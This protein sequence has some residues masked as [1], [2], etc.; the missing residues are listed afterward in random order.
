MK[1]FDTVRVNKP[2]LNKFD[3]SH[4]RKMSLD[5]GNLYPI[6]CEE[7]L[8]GEKWR[9][10]SDVFLRFLALIA[11]VM[12]RVD[13]TVHY[14]FVPN[15]LV[16]K[17]WQTFIS[18][19]EDGLQAPV[20]PKFQMNTVYGVSPAYLRNGSLLDYLGFPT[21]ASGNAL[22]AF[23]NTNQFNLMPLRVYQLIYD[24]FY[25]DQNVEASQISPT[26]FL[27]D[28]LI[29]V[30]DVAATFTLRRRAWEKDYLTSCLPWTQRGAPVSIPI[31]SAITVRGG[32][33]LGSGGYPRMNLAGTGA[34]V[35]VGPVSLDGNPS[36]IST[37]VAGSHLIY[38]PQDT[39]QVSSSSL[40]V[41]ALRQSI[42][43]QQWLENNAR[44]GS[45]YIEQLRAHFGVVSSDARLQRPQYLG[46]GKQPVVIS[47]VL[48]SAPASGGSTGLATMAGHGMSVG[49]TNQFQQYFEEH[50]YVMGLLSVTPRTAYQQGY[51]KT[52]TRL[53]NTD[54]Y[55]PEFAGLGEQSVFGGESYYDCSDGS[56][57][58]QAAFVA[59]FGYQSRYA[60]YK[61]VNSW[62]N[63]DMRENLLYWHFGR[64]FA[65]GSPPALN[66]AFVQCTPRTDPF[67]T[68]NV[69]KLVC[70]IFHKVDAL[71][72]IPYHS[73][74][75]L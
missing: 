40:T 43:L 62:V 12:H 11:P 9:V 36:I 32:G 70:Q 34:P 35:T 10:Q 23:Y 13:V 22:N 4:E 50:G 71:R 49:G 75:N 39:L 73:T 16:W 8:P 29:G 17:N 18:G 41:N 52:W 56:G 3:L 37:G 31:T 1:V 27:D 48:Q 20:P 64:V 60:E 38:D 2:R 65:A 24:Q 5:M 51:R 72:P 67:A 54:Y 74:P 57:A 61:Y 46:G 33:A 58:A 30:A 19:G 66:T 63:G 28:G 45:R 47:E 15:R 14:F 21:I 69:N 6:M 26:T 7:V 25:R 59:T 53:S 42:K 55:F 68:S 44:G